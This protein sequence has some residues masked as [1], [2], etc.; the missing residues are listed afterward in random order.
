M[1][2]ED[3]T[4][5]VTGPTVTVI[6]I[7]TS[8]GNLAKYTGS[9]NYAACVGGR[10]SGTVTPWLSEAPLAGTIHSM[11]MYNNNIGGGTLTAIS[12]TTCI[13]LC[14]LCLALLPTCFS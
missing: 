9:T 6:D 4:A 8:P 7:A 13:G 14:D 2:N 1:I 12:S 11:K 3:N 5:L 10:L